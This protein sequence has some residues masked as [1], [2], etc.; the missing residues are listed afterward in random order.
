MIVVNIVAFLEVRRRFFVCLIIVLHSLGF[1][2][3]SVL[4][5]KNSQAGDAWLG[6]NEDG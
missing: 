3:A 5:Q 1:V 6:K 4:G 2:K